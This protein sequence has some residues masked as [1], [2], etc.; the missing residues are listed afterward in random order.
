MKRLWL[1]FQLWN[2]FCCTKHGVKKHFGR[3]DA[4]CP[5]CEDEYAERRKAHDNYLDSLLKEWNQ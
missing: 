4:Y 1:W 2:N 3:G 5:L